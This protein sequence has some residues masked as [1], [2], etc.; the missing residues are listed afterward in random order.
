MTTIELYTV[1]GSAH[2]PYAARPA[3]ATWGP[4][5]P[6]SVTRLTAERIAD[7]L[8]T[9]DAGCGLSAAWQGAAL[10]FAWDERYRGE[11]GSE[12]IAPDAEGRYR[13]GGLWPWDGVDSV[14]RQ[15][16]FTAGAMLRAALAEHGVTVHTDGVSPSY[17]IP[18]D[19]ATPELEV[20]NRL[21]LLVADRDP[22]VEHAP[23]A[24]TGWLVVLHDENGEPGD[25]IYS[26]GAGD[27]PVDCLT[28][29]V[30]VAAAIADWLNAY[31]S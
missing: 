3:P 13:I 23:S 24:H 29:C 20:Y 22:S 17:A 12:T 16:L 26:A 2:G 31:R 7:D 6:I 11:E 21:H 10:V 25:R 4:Y 19:P 27:E 18:L 28:D 8:N 15:S 5:E 9:R 14:R 1:D 30:A